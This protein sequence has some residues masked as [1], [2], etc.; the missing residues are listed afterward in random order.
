[1]AH[2]TGKVIPPKRK[3]NRLMKKNLPW[4][5]LFAIGTLPF[6]AV[7]LSGFYKALTGFS[8]LAFKSPPSYG[9]TAFFDWVVLF[10]YLFWPFYIIGGLLMVVSIAVMLTKKNHN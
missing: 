5:I 3:E 8:G 1:M 9:L 4:K 7:I 6:F 10:S 2:S